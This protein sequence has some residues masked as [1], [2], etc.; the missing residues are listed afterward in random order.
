MNFR[1]ARALNT[2]IPCTIESAMH[3]SQPRDNQQSTADIDQVTL[4]SQAQIDS[5]A[6][7]INSAKQIQFA[8]IHS[9][10][11]RPW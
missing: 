7:F 3:M 9:A 6:G 4:A 10:L 8:T 2:D 5:F 11:Y 1:I